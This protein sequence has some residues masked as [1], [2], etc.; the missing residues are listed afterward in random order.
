VLTPRDSTDSARRV[1][2]LVPRPADLRPYYSPSRI[3]LRDLAAASMEGRRSRVLIRSLPARCKLAEA[4]RILGMRSP[5]EMSSQDMRS[6]IRPGG[7]FE[8]GIDRLMGLGI[9]I[10]VVVVVEDTF[11]GIVVVGVLVFVAR[12]PRLGIVAVGRRFVSCCGG[13]GRIRSI[14]QWQSL[15]RLQLHHPLWLRLALVMVQVS[16]LEW[17]LG[18]DLGKGS[19]RDCDWEKDWAMGSSLEEIRN[20]WLERRSSR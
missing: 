6:G 17:D 20:C 4:S 7:R 18:W 3:L 8:R 15:R 9:G 13:G 19:V 1:R 5:A 11:A 10:V 16:K 12:A 2:A 14:P